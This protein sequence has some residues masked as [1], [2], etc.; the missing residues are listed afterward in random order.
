MPHAPVITPPKAGLKEAPKVTAISAMPAQQ[1]TSQWDALRQTFAM[2]DCSGDAS[3]VDWARRYTRYPARFEQQLRAVLP[4]LTYVQEIARQY[5]VAGEFVLLPWVESHYQPVRGRA[6]QPAGIWQIMPITA[7]T[8]GLRANGHYD[9]RLD[10]ALAT[11]AVMQMLRQYQDRFHDWR[12]TDYAY[13]AGEFTARRLVEKLGAP[14][15]TPFVP[16]WPVR[17]VTREHLAKL[18]AMACIVRDPQRFG[19]ALPEM[20]QD[21]QL[22]RVSVTRSM[23]LSEVARAA[24]MPLSTLKNLN[25]AYLNNR[26]EATTSAQ[27]MLPAARA[28][29]FSENQRRPI[30]VGSD[31]GLPDP[32]QRVPMH[33][34][35]THRVRT[36]ESLWQIARH[37]AVSVAQLKRW[38]GLHGSRLKPGAVLRVSAVE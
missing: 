13:N 10:L 32:D 9:A 36:G 22:I 16:A 2:P 17:K 18:L 11:T 5:H 35:T 1:D 29:Q 38:N 34:Y 14:A 27:L 30:A 31:R 23:T 19:V 20:A 7:R 25:A 3:A 6:H 15:I 24:G 33:P 37:Y 8:L 21:Q 4:Q 28:Q 26:I 12:V